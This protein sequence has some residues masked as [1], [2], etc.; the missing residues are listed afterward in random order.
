MV[1]HTGRSGL[2]GRPPAWVGCSMWEDFWPVGK[3]KSMRAY[4]VTGHKPLLSP[5]NDEADDLGCD[6]CI[7]RPAAEDS[8]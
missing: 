6:G 5:G 4:Y 7:Q 3:Q 1:P 2:G 8:V